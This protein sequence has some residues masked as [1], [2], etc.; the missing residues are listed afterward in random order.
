MHDVFLSYASDDRERAKRFAVWLE[1]LG[2]SVWWDQTIPPGRKWDE[3]IERE[4]KEASCVIVLW[5]TGSTQSDWVKTEAAEAA[6]R[7]VLVP[8]LIDRVE[9]PLEF[10]RLQA[11]DLSGWKRRAEPPELNLLRQAVSECIGRPHTPPVSRAKSSKRRAIIVGTLASVALLGLIG[12]YFSDTWRGSASELAAASES[13]RLELLK[14]ADESQLYWPYFLEREGGAMLLERAVLLGLESVRRGGDNDA[15]SAALRRALALLSR[16]TREFPHNDYAEAVAISPDGKLL[17]T[18]SRDR[19]AGVWEISS[20]RLLARLNHQD[21]V[22]DIAFSPDGNYI[23]TASRDSTAKLW[24]ASSGREI[25]KMAHPT[26]G[27]FGVSQVA[28]TPNG[29][30]VVTLENRSAHI[31]ALP[32]GRELH[33]LDHAHHLNLAVFSRDGAYLIASAGGRMYSRRPSG[34]RSRG[35]RSLD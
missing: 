16:P 23:A 10:R 27:S 5:S 22:N 4:L 25:A 7:K 28:F 15:G 2:W 6:R 3:T 18:A 11:L 17:A 12:V 26:S 8:V 19:T 31:W 13:L 32:E 35:S 21:G 9:I 24:H 30:G 34:R 14:K 29:A 33:K 20:G 1:S